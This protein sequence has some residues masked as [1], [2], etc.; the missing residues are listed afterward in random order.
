VQVYLLNA[1]VNIHIPYSLQG[2][3]LDIFL[4]IVIKF[5]QSKF[6]IIGYHGKSDTPI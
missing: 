5:G 6:S 3:T 4:F 1:T 2:G